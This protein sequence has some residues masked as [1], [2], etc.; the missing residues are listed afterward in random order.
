MSLRITRSKSNINSIINNGKRGTHNYNS[1]NAGFMVQ[2]PS[3]NQSNNNINIVISILNEIHL[4]KDLRTMYEII[5]DVNTEYYFNNWILMSLKTVQDYYNRAIIRN[6]TRMIS[7]AIHYL[8]M[9]YCIICSY[10]P[11]T[12]KIYYRLDGGSNDFDR[13]LHADF[14][15]KYIP[16]TNPDKLFDFEHWIDIIKSDKYLEMHTMPLI[17]N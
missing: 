12:E 5:N 7:F 3:T 6:Q 11:K 4:P 1:I 15:V 16:D 14:S 17:N 8:S 10:D 9:G 2:N 13:A